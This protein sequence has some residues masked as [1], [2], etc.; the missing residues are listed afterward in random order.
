MIIDLAEALIELC[1]ESKQT[2][3]MYG[4]P[5][6]QTEWEANVKFIN[7]KDE[8]NNALFSDTQPFTYAETKAKL[9]ELLGG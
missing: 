8:N 7:G 5:T 1:K 6:N 9:D 2:F 4:T 3:V